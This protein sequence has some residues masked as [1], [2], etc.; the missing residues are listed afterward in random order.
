MVWPDQGRLFC[1]LFI[2]MDLHAIPT[3]SLTH[4]TGLIHFD[5]L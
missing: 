4:K 1:K 3:A 5:S 2:I